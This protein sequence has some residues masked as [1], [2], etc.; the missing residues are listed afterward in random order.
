MRSTHSRRGF[1]ILL[2][3]A[4]AAP[5]LPACGSKSA[6]AGGNVII[7][8]ANNYS[9]TSSLAIPTVQTAPMADLTFTWDAIANDLL[10]HPAG[11]I[12]NVA[13]LQVKNMMQ[14]DVE[15]KLAVGKLSQNQVADYAEK[16]IV[17][18]DGGAPTSVMLSTF[19]NYDPSS[20]TL[21]TDYVPS[22]TTQYL[23]LFTHGTTLGVGAQSMV[24]IQPTTGVATT[25]VSAPDACA[26]KFLDFTPTL[27]PMTVSIPIAGPWKIDWS[28]ITKDN[29]GNPIDFSTTKLDKV[30]VGFFQAKQ[31]ADVQAD[32]LNV[33][34]DATAL[35]TYAVPTGQKYVDL[36]STPTGGGAF[37]GFAQTDGTWAAAVLCSACSVPAPIVFTVL[38][39][40]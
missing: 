13:F 3:L 14:A 2:P 20:F 34:Q 1:T 15:Q 21:V 29:F 16:H 23:M 24:F 11:T 30:E 27:S 8:D 5:L 4:L 35:Y 32:F 39:P 40:Q 31:P 10:C 12:D 19:D 37:P 7:L 38:T 17:K 26:G 18:A 9:S 6:A 22:T 33:E 36:A 25:M 28:Q